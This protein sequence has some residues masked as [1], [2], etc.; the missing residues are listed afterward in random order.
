MLRVGLALNPPFSNSVPLRTSERPCYDNAVIGHEAFCCIFV[1][2][3]KR[4]ENNIVSFA[5]CE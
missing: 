4:E 3:F 2:V 5:L 1:T